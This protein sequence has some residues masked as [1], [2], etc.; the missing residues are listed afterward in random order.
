MRF[1]TDNIFEARIIERLPLEVLAFAMGKK[2]SQGSEESLFVVAKEKD[3]Q[4]IKNFLDLFAKPYF[5][6]SPDLFEDA[7]SD[8]RIDNVRFVFE[9]LKGSQAQIFLIPTES[10]KNNFITPSDFLRQSLQL[11]ANTKIDQKSLAQK[12]TQLGYRRQTKVFDKS[13]FAIRGDVLDIFVP[14]LDWPLRLET[15]FDEIESLYTFDPK[16][17]QKNSKSL[18]SIT[19]PSLSQKQSD[20]KLSDYLSIAS[21]LRKITLLEIDPES[22]REEIDPLDEGEYQLFQE[23]A[24]K[25]QRII[26]ED[27]PTSEGKSSTQRLAFS[28]QEITPFYLD[29]KKLLEVLKRESLNQKIVLTKEPEKIRQILINEEVSA[30]FRKVEEANEIIKKDES[31]IFV[32]K[33]P[34]DFSLNFNGFVEEQLGLVFLSDFDIFSRRLKRKRAEIDET[35]IASLKEGDFVV[36]ID[37]GVGRFTGMTKRTID[38]GKREFF[39]IEYAKGDKIYLPVEYA[40]KIAKYIGEAKPKI[41]RLHELSFAQVKKQIKED[42]RKI[43][44]ELLDL[45]AERKLYQGFSF[46]KAPH[47]DEFIGL[48]PFTETA[49]QLRAWDEVKADLASAKPMDRLVCGDV[50]FGKTEIALRAAYRVVA[51]KKQ[52]VLLA[53]TTIL[54]KQHFE[55]FQKRFESFSPKLALLS[56]LQNPREQKEIVQKLKDGQLDL[57][58]GTHRLLSKD[59]DFMDLGLII[60]DEEQRFG[61]KAKE[62]LK[63][64]RTKTDILTLTATPIPRTLQMSLSGLK[65][66]STLTTPPEGRKPVETIIRKSSPEIVKKAMQKELDH[67]GQVYYL[68]NR[69]RTIEAA[70]KKIQDYFPEKRIGVVHGQL[71]PKAISETMK[72]FR[73]RKID[74]LIC[75]SIIE[76]GIDFPNVNT[77]I[78]ADATRFGLASLYQLRGRIGRGQ[79]KAFAYF[80]YK[81]LNLGEQAKKRLSALLA[82]KKLGSGF[83]LAMKDLEIRG[84]GNILGKE[85]SGRVK[86]I[87]LSH[88]LK[89][90]NTTIK[91]LKTGKVEKEIDVSI[92]LPLDAY[93]P[94]DLVDN[95]EE[96]LVLYQSLAG[97]ENL[98]KLSKKEAELTQDLEVPELTNLFYILRLKLLSKKAEIKNVDTKIFLEPD[99]SKYKKIVLSFDG[100]TDYKKAYEVLKVF[101]DLEVEDEK[102]KINLKSLGGNWSE[103]LE[104]IV[105]K[106]GG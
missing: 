5:Y 48:F 39:V 91:E 20:A 37:H 6:L 51:N 99:E 31:G 103:N 101:P 10:F 32:F 105:R 89:L 28:P 52:V 8:K 55:T 60:I 25:C 43:A 47:E 3:C 26:F 34:K 9:L 27:L 100:K 67:N 83:E 13:D 45:H 92:D 75:S 57:V 70:K 77:L 84:A 97:I 40:D 41:N 42:T 79:K 102:V 58:I 16:T 66:I 44:K 17:N 22:V 35:F 104:E 64:L 18:K 95:E 24:Q 12:L 23:S 81:N 54:A 78:V 14:Q 11:A 61:V 93:I 30:S 29:P 63:S 62:R 76:N 106:F 71:Y 50:G 80:L 68:H 46:E 72:K 87:G 86:A 4:L 21:S 7:G 49:C 94:T 74:I 82:A 2:T 88:Y 90:L 19:V 36:H 69:V 1:E 85:Q 65:D 73:A 33:V 98:E 53:P 59:I 56:R 96:R 15:S 38:E